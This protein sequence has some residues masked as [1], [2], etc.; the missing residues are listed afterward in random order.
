MGAPQKVRDPV[1]GNCLENGACLDL[2]QAHVRPRIGADRPRE[3]P[4]VAVE[5]G[6]RPEIDRPMRHGPGD[7]VAERVQVGAPVVI[8]DALGVARGAGGVVERDRLP[9]VLGPA[10]V[11]VRVAVG[12]QR[13]VFDAAE[14]VAAFLGRIV[15]IDDQRRCV[16]P[17]ERVGNHGRERAVGEQHLGLGVVE[18][19]AERGGIQPVVERVEHGATHGNAVVRLQHR[20]RVGGHDG[21]RIA[22]ADAALRQRR[23]KAP[24]ARVE[25]GVARST[26]AVNP[27]RPLGEYRSG[28]AQ[29]GERG[30]RDVVRVV[31]LEPGLIRALVGA[32]AA[33]HDLP[34]AE[35]G[36]DSGRAP[37]R[38]QTANTSGSASVNEEAA[39]GGST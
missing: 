14:Q 24:A 3:A 8:D 13:L 29:E 33:H 1:L 6:Q 9:L 11:V 12:Q 28:A 37:P 4:A 23:S 32:R 20:R 15:D 16:G 7:A 38:L 17:R 30:Q 36:R 35:T 26:A 5:H 19:E 21:D 34:I 31:A 10:P 25:F 18:D 22:G 39:C 27:G 2:A